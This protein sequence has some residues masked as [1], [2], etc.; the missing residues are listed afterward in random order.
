MIIYYSCTKLYTCDNEEIKQKTDKQVQRK[1]SC[2][3]SALFFAEGYHH[4]SR[5]VL[6]HLGPVAL[7]FPLWL[8]F[9]RPNRQSNGSQ[10]AAHSGGSSHGSDESTSWAKTRIYHIVISD[11]VRK[12]AWIWLQNQ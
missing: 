5:Q 12:R 10:H 8:G 2:P 3:K 1:Q 7:F 4:G 11:R 9:G 6:V